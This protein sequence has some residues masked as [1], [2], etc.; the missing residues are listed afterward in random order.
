ME[1]IR[2]LLRPPNLELEVT[3]THQNGFVLLIDW[4]DGSLL[5]VL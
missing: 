1:L 3:P 4:H 2:L 5:A